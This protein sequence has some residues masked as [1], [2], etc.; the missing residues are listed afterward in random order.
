MKNITFFNS[1][2]IKLPL[3]LL[4]L[5]AFI[6]SYYDGKTFN[7]FP[8]LYACIIY[9]PLVLFILFN[10]F[11]IAMILTLFVFVLDG[12][13]SLANGVVILSSIL[14][15]TYNHFITLVY[16]IV[17]VIFVVYVAVLCVKRLK[18][19]IEENVFKA[20]DKK[21][22]YSVLVLGLIKLVFMVYNYIAVI[23]NMNDKSNLMNT[24]SSFVCGVLLFIIQTL[25]I[26]SAIKKEYLLKTETK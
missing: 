20:V 11:Q 23:L 19:D 15:A 17:N 14:D 4:Y 26:L 22:V 6:F 18:G 9:V 7:T 21:Y 3:I 2:K 25:F 8:F 12:I 5:I 1:K 24:T 13:G 10:K 16:S